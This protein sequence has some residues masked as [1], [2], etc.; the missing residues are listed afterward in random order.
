M[1]TD[2][3]DIRLMYQNKIDR[4]DMHAGYLTRLIQFQSIGYSVYV[5]HDT[6]VRRSMDEV[7]VF[8]SQS[9]NYLP[10]LI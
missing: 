6:I 1:R 9:L 2:R 3:L 10:M 5:M 7:R 4:I 8:S